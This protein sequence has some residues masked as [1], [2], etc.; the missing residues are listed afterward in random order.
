M[1]FLFS[2]EH[3]ARFSVTQNISSI[4]SFLTNY[5]KSIGQLFPGLASFSEED[6]P[7]L[8]HWEFVPLQY[9]GKSFVIAFDTVFEEKDNE[10]L[11]HPVKTNSQPQL[12]GRFHITRSGQLS[13]IDLSFRLELV[14]P[15][16]SLSKAIISPLAT[17]ELDKLFFEYDRNL[18]NS[19]Q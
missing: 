5:S 6:S 1:S 13:N 11:V 3:S 9:G 7:G 16:P 18:K 12:T 15:F 10:V 4:F 2:Y 17:K 14:A 19:F 8:Y